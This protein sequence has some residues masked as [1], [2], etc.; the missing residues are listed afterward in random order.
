MA[1]PPRVLHHLPSLAAQLPVSGV[2]VLT[3]IDGT[4]SPIVP[5]P[6]EAAVLP[7]CRRALQRLREAGELVVCLSGRA[8]PDAA[9]LVGVPRAVYIGNHGLEELV[10]SHVVL[11]PAAAHL[12]PALDQ[13]AA[14]I[15]RWVDLPGV[16]LE[17]KGVSLSLHYRMAA[18]PETAR[19]RLRAVVDTAVAGL[20]L[21][22]RE[23]RMVIEVLPDIA[24]N[25]G[26]ALRDLLQGTAP[27]AAIY[28]GDDL[29]DLDAMMA[30]R[31]WGHVAGR[32]AVTVGVLSA[33]SPDELARLADYAAGSPAE[34]GA[35]LTWLAERRAGPV[36]AGA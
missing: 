5:V 31:Q 21:R 20:P 17:P 22:V 24:V 36:A 19:K 35:V 12:A 33:E 25:K 13:A 27:A 4:I 26:T 11:A 23:G 10:E 28:F 15:G 1:L 18:D 3:D 32:P 34:V 9:R 16:L 8:A 6:S 30:L 29:T 2:A 14:E 7:E